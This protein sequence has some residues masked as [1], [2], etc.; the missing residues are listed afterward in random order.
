MT[1]ASVMYVIAAIPFITRTRAMW[2]ALFQFGKTK[3]FFVNELSIHVLDFGLYL[4][5]F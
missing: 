3:Y 4:Q 2:W 1:P 5:A